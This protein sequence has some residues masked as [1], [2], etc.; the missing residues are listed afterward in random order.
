MT[1]AILHQKEYW[2]ELNEVMERDDFMDVQAKY[3]L[4]DLQEPP[5]EP[6]CAQQ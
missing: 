2:P 6:E 5:D 4:P 3:G 1:R